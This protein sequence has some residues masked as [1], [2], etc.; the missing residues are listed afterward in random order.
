MTD[1]KPLQELLI[2]INRMQDYQTSL[3]KDHIRKEDAIRKM[4]SNISHDLKTPLTVILG[5]MEII[6]IKGQEMPAEEREILLDKVYKKT[7]DMIAFINTFFDLAK[8]ES[9]D[10]QVP[11]SAVDLAE[12]CRRNALHFYDLMQMKGLKAEFIIPDTPVLVMGNESA[13]DRVLQNLLHN[14]IQHGALGK[15]VGLELQA[16]ESQIQLDIWDQ[17]KGIKEKDQNRI[18]ERLFTLEES[19]NKAFQGSGLGLTITKRLVEA[20]G[21]LIQLTSEPFKKTTF[22]IIFTRKELL[23]NN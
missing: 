8:L 17:G 1:W 6:Q 14:A 15:V 19:R 18:F 13:L 5:Y 16:S 9:G 20:M 10:E 23:R 21:G 22:T 2:Q 7:K 3:R 12:V 4:I 11:L